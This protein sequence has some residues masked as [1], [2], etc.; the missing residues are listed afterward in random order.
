MSTAGFCRRESAHTRVCAQARTGIV[1]DSHTKAL[2]TT[3]VL[4]SSSS[5][6]VRDVKQRT[7]GS[8]A[9]V[10]DNGNLKM[11]LFPFSVGDNGNIVIK[12]SIR[13]CGFRLSRTPLL[14]YSL[15]SFF[16]Y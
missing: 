8:Q 15:A 4:C 16:T 13:G 9:S 11:L 6:K 5:L 2:N 12:K 1:L 3:G 7:T 14:S 10:R